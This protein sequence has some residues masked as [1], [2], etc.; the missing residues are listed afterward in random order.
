MTSNGGVGG[1]GILVFREKKNCVGPIGYWIQQS[2]SCYP[3]DGGYDMLD[4]VQEPGKIMK[5][6]FQACL[7]KMG[8]LERLEQGYLRPGLQCAARGW[9][10]LESPVLD[11]NIKI[12]EL[13]NTNNI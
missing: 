7:F 1:L 5:F 12:L 9:F 8:L 10:K 2:F 4:S 13:G 3:D 11:L 6:Y